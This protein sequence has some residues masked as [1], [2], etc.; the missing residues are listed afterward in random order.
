MCVLLPPQIERLS[1]LSLLA[2]PFRES[3]RLPLTLIGVVE[4]PPE[5]EE[6]IVAF[7]D[8]SLLNFVCNLLEGFLL[9]HVCFEYAE[10]S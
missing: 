5:V 8:P 9:Y 3:L 2:H 10:D 6:N 4:A 1:Q 7:A